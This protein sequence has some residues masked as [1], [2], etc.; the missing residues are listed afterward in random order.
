MDMS[1][2]KIEWGYTPVKF[3][4]SV[5]EREHK[6]RDGNID[7]A[8]TFT[9]YD[10][11]MSIQ[12]DGKYAY[13]SNNYGLHLI[14]KGFFNEIYEIKIKEK[15]FVI[16]NIIIAT[17]DED[18]KLIYDSEPN[19]LILQTNN[20][21][22][23]WR[24]GS[25]L[26]CDVLNSSDKNCNVVYSLSPIRNKNNVQWLH[27]SCNGILYGEF[28][29]ELMNINKYLSFGDVVYSIIL[30]ET[31]DIIINNEIYLHKE[32]HIK[33]DFYTLKSI[34]NGLT[35]AL[36]S[37]RGEYKWC[38]NYI[39]NRPLYASRIYIGDSF[40]EGEMLYCHNYSLIILE[41][42]LIY[43]NHVDGTE[44]VVYSVPNVRLTSLAVTDR[45]I[46]LLSDNKVQ[47]TLS[48]NLAES[49]TNSFLSCD[50]SDNSVYWDDGNG[51]VLW[52]YSINNSSNSKSNAVLL[53]N[54]YYNKCLYAEPYTNEPITYEDCKNKD[55]YKW[56]YV[57]ID[58]S[59]Y[60]KSA[61]KE[62]LCIRVSK[63][64]IVL[65]NCD[66]N[67]IIKYIKTSKFIKRDDKCVSGIDD[68]DD[69][70]SQYYVKLSNCDRRNKKQLWEFISDINDISN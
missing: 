12:S 54:K 1:T 30:S 57:N 55:K 40:E 37:S 24:Y 69:L 63:N 60:F 65:G 52:K 19:S 31:G 22:M 61:S 27:L 26:Y 18:L 2:H 16:N 38:S 62:N 8:N 6:D 44:K 33:E 35:L 39:N 4:D 3:L 64:R 41:G 13:I 9:T 45:N 50:F 7:V 17:H 46:V 29:M 28:Y 66:K 21:E 70:D 53:Y 43:R 47:Y 56:Y 67:A 42:N 23:V 59:T 20:K 34:N 36:K 68:K 14:G 49:N 58:G 11:L 48:D 5:E 51:K 15:K 10:R 25:F 32:Y